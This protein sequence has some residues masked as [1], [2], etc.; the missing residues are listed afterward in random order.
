MSKIIFSNYDDLGNPFYGGGG[1]AAIHQVARRLRHKHQVTVLTGAYPGS[2][3]EIIEGVPYERIGTGWGPKLGQLQFH[4]SL[5][6][7][8][9][10]RTCD[11]WIESLTPPFSTACL[12]RFTQKPVALLTQNLPGAAMARKYKL[13]FR[14][15]E[16]LGLKTYR[17]GIA[18]SEPIKSALLKSNPRMKV[19]VI[20]NGVSPE[21]INQATR[22]EGKSI[23]FLGR[24]DLQQKG[25]DLLLEAV[26]RLSPS[27][28]LPVVIAGSGIETE[29][30]RLK[31]SIAQR[32]LGN[33]VRL[34]G[35]VIGVEKDNVFRDALFFVM[36]SRFEG[37][38]L[39]CL[40]A[41]CWELPVVLFAIPELAWLPDSCC[42][43]VQPF[44]VQGLGS[45]IGGLAANP[46]RCREMGRAAKLW[47]RRF[48]WDNIAEEYARFFASILG[49]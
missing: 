25:L 15:F 40:E 3:D 28:V 43:K 13:P 42:V 49:S 44:D 17:Y 1:A 31:G 18:L 35:K 4:F 38:P 5:P 33:R 20:P 12:Q 24:L 26:Q 41:F 32:G 22:P 2:R 34:T 8:V 30:N 14:W 37:F 7:Q 48:N 47:V 11:I 23:L 19:E 27:V 16:H 46:E 21:L 36:P 45:A 10:R 6:R 39:A 9:R 29:E